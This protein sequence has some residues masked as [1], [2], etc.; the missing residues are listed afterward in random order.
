M[1]DSVGERGEGGAE[2]IDL[3]GEAGEGSW[4]VAPVS[5]FLDHGVESPV[6]VERGPADP[7][8]FGNRGERDRL[9]S[10]DEFTADRLDVGWA[11]GHPV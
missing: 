6:A 5:M 2:V 11:G 4:V 3:G 10:S 8:V 7:G 1:A 9:A